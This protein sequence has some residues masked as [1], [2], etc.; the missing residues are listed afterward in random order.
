MLTATTD[1]FLFSLLFSCVL[2]P[3]C[4]LTV[5]ISFCILSHRDLPPYQQCLPEQGKVFVIVS[6]AFSPEVSVQFP[7]C[8]DVQVS[9][10]LPSFLNLQAQPMVACSCFCIPKKSRELKLIGTD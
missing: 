7:F 5:E 4:H 8:C 2:G 6:V 3:A 1:D 10:A 9:S